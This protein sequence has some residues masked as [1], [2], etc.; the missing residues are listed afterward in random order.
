VRISC[1]QVYD[2]NTGNAVTANLS[3]ADTAATTATKSST[4]PPGEIYAVL[5]RC[6]AAKSTAAATATAK[7]M[8]SAVY[9]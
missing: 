3:G 7:Q 5:L 1:V 8:P 9:R 6:S 4:N 2:H